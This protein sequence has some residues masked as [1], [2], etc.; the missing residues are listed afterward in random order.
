[1]L[2][3]TSPGLVARPDGMF[4]QA[5]MMPTTIERRLQF[6]DRAQRAEHAAPRRTCRTSSRP[7]RPRLDRDA[8]GV[9]RDALADQHVR[10]GAALLRLQSISKTMKR[11]GW[12]LPLVTDRNEPISSS[13]HSL[14]SRIVTLTSGNSSPSCWARAAEV[15]R[16]AD[17]P[18]HIAEVARHVHTMGDREA[19][20]RGRFAGGQVR[21]LR[22]RKREL[23][24]RP[25]H[26]GGLA[27]HL[28]ETVDGL[29][30]DHDTCS[31]RHATS[32]RLTFSSVR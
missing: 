2:V 14:R 5:G 23:A 28:L 9:E 13:S 16:R 32:R 4:S 1:M 20:R 21:A 29:H 19:A 31:T 3:T 18:R 12:S 10:L 22:H 7:W 6:G 17:V 30:G 25:P 24:Q 11:G 15:G 8:A 26:L 27:L